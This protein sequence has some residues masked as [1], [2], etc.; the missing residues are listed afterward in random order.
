LSFLVAKRR[1]AIG[2]VAAWVIATVEGAARLDAT[3][4]RALGRDENWD[5][6]RLPL[7]GPRGGDL[8]LLLDPDF[9]YS[10]PRFAL[11]RRTD[12][13]RAP[14]IET[15]GR[16]CLAGDGGRADTLDPVAV[17]AYSYGEALALIDEDEAGGN[18]DDYAID[19]DAYWRRDVTDPLTLRT[20][21]TAE[22]PSRLVSA[23]HGQGFYFIAENASDAR[24]WL[25]N[26]YGADGTRTFNDAALIW[27]DRLPEPESYPGSTGE[28]RGLIEAG[29]ADGVAIFDRLMA[30]MADRAAVVLI[31]RTATGDIVQAG[32]VAEDPNWANTGTK[33]P[34]PSVTRGFRPGRV[35]ARILALRRPSRRLE[36]QRT[37][38]WLGRMRAGEGVRLA[39]KRVAVLGCG[40]LGGGVAKLLLQSGVGRMILVD[41]DTFAWVNVG[42]HELGS[43]SAEQNK[44]TALVER[45]RPMYPH[46]RELRAEPTSWQALLRRNPEV[47]QDCDLILSLIGDW[48]AES[49]LNDLQRSGMDEIRAPILYGWLEEQ[50]GAAHALAI[51]PTGACL[52]CGFGP[53]GT[54][55][56]PATAWPRHASA[57]CGGPTSI[58]GAVDLAPAQSLVASLAIDLLLERASPAVRRAWLAPQPTL[59][60]GGGRW[61]PGWVEH[62]GDPLQGGKLTATLWPRDVD[63][64]CALPPATSAS[65]HLGQVLASSSAAM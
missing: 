33:A 28:A 43:D 34:K 35:P 2:L 23:W 27:L 60:H 54:I 65:H 59:A 44:A 56:V 64:S 15:K 6:W 26:R 42:R 38:A 61:H 19:F 4:L 58:Y 5:G 51:G 37:D 25:T 20:W 30:T 3:S 14:H 36:V 41:P 45:F 55:H 46:A 22:R 29:S 32:L 62:Y 1:E 48:N 39:A 24:T 17:V 18:R 63:C 52:R 21:L 53:T 31:G 11:G 47:F 7:R 8:H 13:L 10:L 49:A 9:P 50:A 57:G 12:L 40:S 16:L